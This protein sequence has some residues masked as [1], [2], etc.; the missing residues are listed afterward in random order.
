MKILLA[1]EYSRLHNSLKEGLLA[2][3]HEVTLIGFGDGFKNYPSDIL[4]KKKWDS[5]WKKKLKVGL[6]ISSRLTWR[7]FRKIKHLARGF[8]VVQ[9][10]NENTFYCQPEI[11]KKILGYL[12]DHNEQVFLLSCGD[13]Y[14]Y[15]SYCFSHPE[16]KSVI[17]PYLEG[18]VKAKDFENVLKFRRPSFENLHRYIYSKIAGVISSDLD[19]HVP[20]SGHPKYLG[21]I[22]NPVN[23]DKI[24]FIPNDLSGRIVIFHGINTE[25]YYKKGSDH[26]DA[27]LKIVRTLSDKIDIVSVKSLPYEQYIEI[28]CKAHII[29]DQAFANDQGYNALE[30]M[31][32]GKVVFTGAEDVFT[33]HYQLKEKVNYNAVPKEGVISEQLISLINDRDLLER[34]GK[35]ARIFIERE[36]HY[37]E[38]ASK[39]ISAWTQ[40]SRS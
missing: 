36:H 31:A 39:Y 37:I 28:Y 17:Q 10:I 13:D 35:A 3:G 16:Y 34:I 27:A 5:G 11:E 29:L 18:K 25:S 23:I 19:Y 38:I 8:D 21:M 40:K 14:P 1:G 2:L 26:F 9:L 6:D 32:M 33:Q 4:L 20:L 24:E 30:A 22:A 7:Q 12:F 15:V